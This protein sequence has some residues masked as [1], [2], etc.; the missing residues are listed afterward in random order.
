MINNSL[1]SVLNENQQ[2]GDCESEQERSPHFTRK[3]RDNCITQVTFMRITHLQ[4]H[5]VLHENN[6]VI[7]NFY[8][9]VYFQKAFLTLRL[10]GPLVTNYK[11]GYT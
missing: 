3:M 6:T 11:D 4:V 7:T 2:C 9:L 1:F 10:F 5:S 8:S